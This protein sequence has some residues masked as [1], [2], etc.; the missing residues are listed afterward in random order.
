MYN[1]SSKQYSQGNYDEE[2]TYDAFKENVVNF[3]G[4]S[5]STIYGQNTMSY[6]E[7]ELST[8]TDGTVNYTFD[9]SQLTD[10]QE[11]FIGANRVESF[12]QIDNGE[13]GTVNRHRYY[14]N[15]S[16][17]TAT[18]T[19][20]TEYNAYGQ[21]IG[22]KYNNVLL[23]EYLYTDGVESIGAQKVEAIVDGYSSRLC[24][25]TTDDKG[26][27]VKNTIYN[28]NGSIEFS[29]SKTDDNSFAYSVGNDVFTFEVEKSDYLNKIIVK[30][31]H[32]V[33]IG[34]LLALLFSFNF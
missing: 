25:C 6:S 16:S 17:A 24:T 28:E 20:E 19:I 27:I 3:K 13:A 32:N 7:D 22:E 11:Y 26:E 9:I 10:T 30:D 12:A 29:L 15:S 2:Y 4:K 1:E 8:V 31:R 18:D 14:R 34:L 5:G 33:N 21:I 23:V